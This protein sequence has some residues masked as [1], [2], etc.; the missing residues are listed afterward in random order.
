MQDEEIKKDETTPI[1]VEVSETEV[2]ETEEGTEANVKKVVVT[3]A[4][5]AGEDTK[6]EI[7]TEETESSETA[8]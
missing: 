7:V 5:V 4:H 3:G 8:E 6:V 2:T 1:T